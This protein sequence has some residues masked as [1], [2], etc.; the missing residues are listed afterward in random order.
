MKGLMTMSACD[1]EFAQL[2][3]AYHDGRLDDAAAERI[4]HELRRIDRER[5]LEAQRD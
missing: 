5:H 2:V 3:A 1:S 4:A